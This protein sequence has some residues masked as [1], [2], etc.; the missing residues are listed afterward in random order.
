M[1][2][3]PSAAMHAPAPG[4]TLPIRLPLTALLTTTAVCAIG[5]W[6]EAGKELASAPSAWFCRYDIRELICV[7]RPKFLTPVTPELAS[8]AVH[9]GEA[10][11]ERR[12]MRA[13][14]ARID[15]PH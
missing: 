10:H 3:A 13:V 15:L 8:D 4:A 7:Y 1:R 5:R 12:R 11:R 14:G 2:G 9:D 6:K